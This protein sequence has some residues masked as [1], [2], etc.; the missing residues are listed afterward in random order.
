VVATLNDLVE[1]GLAVREPDP[2]DGRRNVVSLTKPGV[3]KLDRLD[4]V[5]DD[6]QSA[7]LA[8][9][10]ANERKALV[11]LLSKLT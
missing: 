4:A 2:L 1:L 3:A 9:L 5:L 10:T 8:P 6:V 7:V 11:R